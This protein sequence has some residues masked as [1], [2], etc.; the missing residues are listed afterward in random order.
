[1]VSDRDWSNRSFKEMSTSTG[2]TER[3]P[4]EIPLVQI[5]RTDDRG[6]PT[7]NTGDRG[8]TTYSPGNTSTQRS[9]FDIPAANNGGVRTDNTQPVPT[10]TNNGQWRSGYGG[11]APTAID[12]TG[13]QTQQQQQQTPLGNGQWRSGYGGVAPIAIDATRNGN[14]TPQTYDPNQNGGRSP[15]N[16]VAPGG[17]DLPP[18]DPN[19]NGGVTN[20]GDPGRWQPSPN[21]I[22]PGVG[23]GG[24]VDGSG[25]RIGSDPVATTGNGGIG[26]PSDQQKQWVD[27][28]LHTHLN[29]FTHF[30]EGGIGGVLGSS[31]LP[32]AGDKLMWKPSLDGN[33]VAE[34]WRANHSPLG[35]QLRS[36][37]G[38]IAE[39]IQAG[40]EL[41]GPLSA[42]QIQF[43]QAASEFRG[44]PGTPTS[45]ATG[46]RAMEEMHSSASTGFAADPAN[47][48][49]GK[50]AQLLDDML[51]SRPAT[52]EEFAA[53][54]QRIDAARMPSDTSPMSETSYLQ[55]AE[56]QLLRG[57][58]DKY[59]NLLQSKDAVET[60]RG[61]VGE[62]QAQVAAAQQ[63]RDAIRARGGD[64]NA[65]GTNKTW[66]DN[67]RP[68]AGK[69]ETE[70]TTWKGN[71]GPLGKGR[72]FAEGVGVVAAGLG[73]NYLVDKYMPNMFGL[74]GGKDAQMGDHWRSYL[75]GPAITAALIWPN[76]SA[77]WKA[78]A[79]VAST[80]AIGV[81]EH[82]FPEK[83]NGS[84]SKLMQPNWIDS[85][86]MG[87]A[88]ML[89]FANW[90]SRAIAVGAT[91]GLAR[92]AD[93]LNNVVG[94]HVPGIGDQNF[95]VGM[96]DDVASA[97]A[98]KKVSNGTFKDI[99]SS[100]YKLGMENEGALLANLGTF[101]NDKTQDPL[102]HL[103]GS[104][105]M[106]TALGD[107]YTSRGPRITPGTLN[108]KGRIMPDADGYDLGGQAAGFYRQA[109]ANLVEGQNQAARN[110][111]GDAKKAMED[112]QKEVMA[113]LDK[114]YGD[115]NISDV[116]GKAKKAYT[117]DIDGIAHYQVALK[118]QV[119]S[120]Q[121]RDTKYAGKMCRDIALLDL[122][123][124]SVK[125]EKNDGGGAQIMYAEALQFI[126]AAERIDGNSKD[127]KQIR[128]ISDSMKNLVPQAV[129]NQYNSTV[130][131]PF[132][133][134][135]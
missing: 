28:S 38:T 135:K 122:A 92:G 4:F 37:D 23:P 66:N 51:K 84:Y 34:Y 17:R 3:S 68:N 94:V 76:K 24:G 93:F 89:P 18:M 53:M 106:F 111:N 7:Y 12:A 2:E 121:T 31:V 129:N 98:S 67:V 91:W 105:A 49:L 19:A 108:D 82:M 44:V 113:R 35:L 103:H 107:V 130:N 100:S 134:G 32:W 114:I 131:N 95:A 72:A 56:A 87:A 99:E 8:T 125:A 70:L 75:Q 26:A 126:Q 59:K 1:M 14:Q 120:L 119:S 27:Q 71:E 88:W 65:A 83:A 62:N 90:K 30:V 116:F 109:V 104:A 39:L 81:A 127:V 112:S 6:Y 15:Y 74:V 102:Y 41:T 133:V 85:V 40:S 52:P 78:S 33:R 110:N 36:S 16:G 63:T 60:L 55:S 86:G 43:R 117:Q 123:I 61:A 64:F 22:G 57:N 96:Q 128:Q 50:K 11:V 48:A 10:Q 25:Q 132:G 20:P 58:L 124:A 13:Q 77:L 118:Q 42:A 45:A 80:V 21:Q 47:L 69:L 79:A 54:R 5:A 101:M 9:P 29:Y 97:I 115:H 73:A 46:L